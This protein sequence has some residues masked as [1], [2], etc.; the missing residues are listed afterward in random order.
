MKKV[1]F[2]G[3]DGLSWNVLN[4]LME[5]NELPNFKRLIQGASYG[6][7]EAEEPLISP[8]IWTSMFTG[9]KPENHGIID[10]YSKKGDLE[11]SQIWDILHQKGFKLGIY[12]PL[13]TWD[14]L[15]VEG[16]FIPCFLAFKKVA[17]PKKYTVIAE[18]DQKAREDK[19]KGLSPGD[20]IK[21]F[22]KFLKLGFPLKILVKIILN[23]ISLVLRRDPKKRLY[24]IKKIEFNIHS[25][26]FLK[27]TK[28]FSPELSL[29]YENSCD[30]LSHRFWRDYVSGSTYSSVLPKMYRKID[31]YVGKVLKYAQK[32]DI[33]LLVISDHGFKTIK[34]MKA[35]NKIISLKILELLDVLGLQ[36]D[37][38][39][40]SLA[41]TFVFRLKPNSEIDLERFKNLVDSISCEGKPLFSTELKDEFLIV[42]I[43]LSF[44][45]GSTDLTVDLPDGNKI[46]ISQ[47]L[48]F[49]SENTG[50]HSSKDG[51]FIITGPNIKAGQNI[52]T[53]RPYDI[54]PTILA[55]LNANIPSDM[56]GKVLN[57][58][59]RKGPK[60]DYYNPKE[61]GVHGDKKAL[62]EDEEEIIKKR[63]KTL[64]YL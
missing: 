18:L 5:N 60:V 47:I 57:K 12:R 30:S 63:L 22:W 45:P 58:I 64:G 27:L 51:V 49:N 4:E 7:M 48:D 28:K 42:A 52:G 59:F 17:H 36:N 41:E 24:A 15:P 9:K 50:T 25:G 61:K 56:D 11:S 35:Q 32:N 23:S 37:A 8:R 53:I 55:I 3:L 38:Y 20:M 29:L 10:F 40:E 2:M 39:G 44:D 21:S 33:T 34:G 46:S 31:K 43:N 26:F 1:I 16:F 13:G 6:I 54:T 14:A 19:E 62:S